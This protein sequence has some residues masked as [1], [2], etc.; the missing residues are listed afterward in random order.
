LEG[1]DEATYNFEIQVRDR[2]GNLSNWE[3]TSTT[4]SL[5]KPEIEVESGRLEFEA[6]K[7]VLDPESQILTISN[8]GQAFLGWEAVVPSAGGWLNLSLISGGIPAGGSS[9][10]SVSVNVLT[11]M[12]PDLYS[13]QIQILSNAGEK[14]ILVSLDL[15]PEP[16]PQIKITNPEEEQTFIYPQT[17]I[18]IKGNANSGN[19][20]FI[21]E[22]DYQTQA[23]GNGVWEIEGVNL[24]SGS[25]VF[26]ITARN[27]TGDEVATSLTVFLEI[28]V[29]EVS[30]E[31]IDLEAVKGKESPEGQI[32]I[33]NIG[34]GNLNWS[35]TSAAEWLEL[36][37]NFGTVSASSSIIAK[38]SVKNLPDLELKYS[39]IKDKLYIKSDNASNSPKQ[40]LV[41]LEIAPNSDLDEDGV[42]DAYDPETIIDEEITLEAGEY[43][44]RDLILEP[45]AKL[46]LK[47]NL[48]PEFSGFRGVKINGENININY[49]ASILADGKGYPAGEGPGAGKVGDGFISGGSYGGIGG[50][51]TATSTYGVPEHPIELGSGG[52]MVTAGGGAVIFNVSNTLTLAGFILVNGESSGSWWSGGSGG[53]VYITTKT[54]SGSGSVFANGG[55][56]C[57][58]YGGVGAGGGGGRIAIYYDVNNFTGSL[59]TYGGRG[60]GNGGPGTI[61]LKSSAQEN[62]DLIIDNNGLGGATQLPEKNYT[63][64]QLEILN[65]SYFYLPESLTANEIKVSNSSTLE[66]KTTTTINVVN[67]LIIDSS[68]LIGPDRIFLNIKGGDLFFQ[69]GSKIKANL[70]ID[71]NNLEID[72]SSFISANGKGYPA[73]EGPGAGK[74]YGVGGSYGGRGGGNTATSTY[75]DLKHPT[76][77]GSG[78]FGVAGGGAIIIEVSDTLIL[79][80]KIY[81]NGEGH[82]F[83]GGGSGGSVYITTD[84]FAGSGSIYTNGGDGC[85]YGGGIGQGGGGGRIAI[86]YNSSSFD[87]NNIKC[88]G[89]WRMS[90]SGEDGTIVI[91]GEPR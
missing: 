71:A 62:G 27:Q 17:Q 75:G 81:A 22:T 68:S 65:S 53:S 30:P 52:A 33:K 48:N 25:N 59:Q 47:S 91:N 76:D 11:E 2:A 7:F 6:V 37:P 13:T 80:G 15:K 4:I 57:T 41:N 49:G 77:L 54:F 21:S 19:Y 29:L 12:E 31:K 1:K 87:E 40:V 69:S 61:Y 5:P 43:S 86:Y 24:N 44:F 51:N 63:F 84:T 83:Y 90:Q 36:E 38:L 3:S 82:P 39:S 28:P 64:N 85:T 8:P 58:Y 9:T 55:D 67:Q 88:K 50:A 79:D 23:D 18:S 70:N 89:G 35:A 60:R 42:V 16:L 73:G 34:D 20:I 78:S 72:K 46:V 66:A 45:G 32:T 26:D 14:E 56:G 10:I 74:E